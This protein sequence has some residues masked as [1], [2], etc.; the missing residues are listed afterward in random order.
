M[1]ENNYN[2]TDLQKSD[3]VIGWFGFFN[4]KSRI[5]K[6]KDRKVFFI[7]LPKTATTSATYTLEQ[8]KYRSEHFPYLLVNY[9]D[10]RLFYNSK[11]LK[12]H[13]AVSDL[14]VSASLENIV[15]EYPDALY[16][17]TYRDKQKWLNSCERHPWPLEILH[18]PDIVK[19]L[20]KNS[21]NNKLFSILL[22]NCKKLEL[23]HEKVLGSSIFV[24]EIFSD[25]HDRYEKKV[26]NLLSRR[27]NFLKLNIADRVDD[28]TKLGDFLNLD[29][30]GSFE[31]KDCFYTFLF[32][33]LAEIFG[34][35]RIRE[36]REEQ[37]KRYLSGEYSPGIT[38]LGSM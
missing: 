34:W 19:Y 7:G 37:R 10:G 15:Q 3:M 13:D 22:N 21:K 20:Q 29:I 31:K 16:I 6:R 5:V 38:K 24:P 11:D 14:P 27:K 2:N 8:A 4:I 25:Y 36:I 30:N 35:D 18:Y 26:M 32:K 1:K 9:K 17:Y 33:K 23:M 12:R 28:K